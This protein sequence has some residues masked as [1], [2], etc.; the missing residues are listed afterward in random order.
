MAEREQPSTILLIEDDHTHALLIRSVLEKEGYFFIHAMNM[1][2]GYRYVEHLRPALVIMDVMLPD[3]SGYDLCR[4][5]RAHPMLARTPII[6][7]SGRE[8]IEDK[9][10]GFDAGADHY[11][12]KPLQFQELSL[13]TNALLRRSKDQEEQDGILRAEDFSIDPRSRCVVT[14]G[15]A[16][17]HLTSREFDLLYELVRCRPNVVS[18][19]HIIKNLWRKTLRDNTLDVHIKNIRAKLGAAGSRIVTIAG[20][21]Y[22]FR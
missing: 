7:L 4:R 10:K 16:I 5:I 15:K 20:E 22:S 9:Q 18:R 3:G 21:G 17:T 1:A 11:L 2:D 12:V 8:S 13:W 14:A 19:D 6:L